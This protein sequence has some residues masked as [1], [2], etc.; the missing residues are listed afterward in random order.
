MYIW[1]IIDIC[2]SFTS[3]SLF[4]ISFF[5]DK[6]FVYSIPL[7]FNGFSSILVSVI[8]GRKCSLE[9]GEKEKINQSIYDNQHVDGNAENHEVEML[10]SP[11]GKNMNITYQGL[12]T[13][14]PTLVGK[15]NKIPHQGMDAK[16]KHNFMNEI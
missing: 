7:I 15:N 8:Y 14:T 4:L 16:P 9:S 11:M 1:N 3:I 6:Y 5:V 2:N 13:Q 10:T 12:K